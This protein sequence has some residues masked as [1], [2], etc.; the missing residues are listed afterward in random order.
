VESD[1]RRDGWPFGRFIAV[2]PHTAGLLYAFLTTGVYKSVDGG[3][4][5]S[6]STDKQGPIVFDPASA[7]TVYLLSD[8]EG[9]LKST[10]NGATWVQVTKG[11][12]GPVTSALAFEPLKP[13]TLYLAT[14][15]SGGNDS[16]VA[17]INPNGSALLYSTFLGGMLSTTDFTGRERAGAGG[18]TRQFRQHLRRGRGPVAEFSHDA[19][20]V[21]A[22][23]PRD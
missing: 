2:S 8:F 13:S 21:S 17:K 5:W 4:T 12:S 11:Y 16:F 3:D 19:K 15:P 18:R 7:S 6:K 1:W 22:L 20:F 23:T 10:D 9:L 14:L